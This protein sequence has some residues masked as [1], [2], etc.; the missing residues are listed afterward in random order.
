MSRVGQRAAAIFAVGFVLLWCADY[1]WFGIRLLV[2]SESDLSYSSPVSRL[3]AQAGLFGILFSS[4]V[5]VHASAKHAVSFGVLAGLFAW[6][7]HNLYLFQRLPLT[8]WNTGYILL[9]AGISLST[10][11]QWALLGYLAGRLSRAIGA[12]SRAA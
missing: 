9:L 2:S 3:V 5:A 4:F 11:L 10:T 8:D 1:V 12:E 6:V 7:P